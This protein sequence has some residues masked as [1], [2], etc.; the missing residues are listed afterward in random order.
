MTETIASARANPATKN[1]SVASIVY[2]YAKKNLPLMTNDNDNE[3]F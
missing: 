2:A 3:P 1:F